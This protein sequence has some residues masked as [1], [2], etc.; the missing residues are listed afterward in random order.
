MRKSD[1]VTG[2]AWF[3]CTLWLAEYY[4]A[5]AKKADRSR[6]AARDS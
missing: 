6:E 1:D 3:I 5:M 2:N 4:I